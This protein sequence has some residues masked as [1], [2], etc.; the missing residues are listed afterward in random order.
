MKL[1]KKREFYRCGLICLSIF[2]CEDLRGSGYIED[3]VML[4]VIQIVFVYSISYGSIYLASLVEG[5]SS[6]NDEK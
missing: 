3:D 2:W 4:I 5:D 1:D 6:R